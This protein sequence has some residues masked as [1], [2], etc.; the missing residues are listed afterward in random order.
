M[1]KSFRGLITDGEQQEIRLSTNNGLTGYKIVKF[2]VLPTNTTSGTN[3]AMVSIW[4]SA[5]DSAP[6]DVEF[7]SPLLIGAAFYLRDQATVASTSETIIFDNTTFN[8]DIHVT[9]QN[10][11]GTTAAI[12]YYIELEAV[13]LDL[14]EATVATLKDMR[15]GPDTNF[16]P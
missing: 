7:S 4:K 3:E 2:Q 10:T 14:N 12:N 9:H 16:G 5:Q 6:Q 13:K 1:N 11:G 8:Q 15:A